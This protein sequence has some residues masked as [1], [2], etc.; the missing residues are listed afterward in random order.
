MVCAHGSM[1]RLIFHANIFFSKKEDTSG[2]ASINL[3]SLLFFYQSLLLLQ[4][5]RTQ[6]I[7]TTHMNTSICEGS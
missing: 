7:I 6:Q 3:Y 4:V 5:R 1:F 2:L